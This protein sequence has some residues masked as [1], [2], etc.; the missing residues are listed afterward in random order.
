MVSEMTEEI[1]ELWELSTF[2]DKSIVIIRTGDR[3][4][5]FV[6]WSSDCPGDPDEEAQARLMVAAPDLLT[7]CEA[8]VEAWEKCLQLEKT[9]IALQKA[10]A[11]IAKAKGENDA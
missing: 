5:D 1:S 10:K 8:F 9:D 4:S 11:A 3:P 7:A 6:I 2:P